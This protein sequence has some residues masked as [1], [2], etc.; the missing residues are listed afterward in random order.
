MILPKNQH[1]Q[2][3]PEMLPI[4]AAKA[5]SKLK[6][7]KVSKVNK[8][9]VYHLIIEIGDVEIYSSWFLPTWPIRVC[10]MW[11]LNALKRPKIP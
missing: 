10:L 4:L 8:L 11:P 6:V 3:G 2:N 7:F 9:S 1:F 5:L